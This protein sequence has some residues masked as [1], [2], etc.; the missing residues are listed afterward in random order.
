LSQLQA[1]VVK[2]KAAVSKA[3]ILLKAA[4]AGIHNLEREHGHLISNIPDLEAQKKVAATKLDFKAAS[5]ASKEIKDA[6]AHL[7]KCKEELV[8]EAANHKIAAE[9]ELAQQK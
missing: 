9:G 3:K 7:K 8:G 6:A 2:C 1:D 4:T 5:K